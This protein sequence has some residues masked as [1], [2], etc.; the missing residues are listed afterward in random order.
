[1]AAIVARAMGHGN[2]RMAENLRHP[3]PRP[4]GN[5][6][7]A[8]SAGDAQGQ[9]RPDQQLHCRPSHLSPGPVLDPDVLYGSVD[10]Q[11]FAA[12]EPTI[13]ARYSRRYFGK[14]KGVVAYTLLANHVPL[15]TEL[16]GANE[17]ESHYVFDIWY[18]NTSA[19]VPTTITGDMHSVNKANFA[20]T[21]W[22][23][24]KFAPRFTSLQAQLQHLYCASDIAQ[25]EA[26]LLSPAG[27]IDRGLITPEKDNVDRIIAT[28][29]LKEM[30]QVRRSASCAP[31]PSKI[32]PERLSSNS[33]SWSAASTRSTTFGTRNCN[34]MSI[35]PRIVSKPIISCARPSHKSRQEA[36]DRH[37][38]T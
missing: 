10:G 29:G 1:M 7:A 18:H 14:G 15:E 8:Y 27:Q 5:R 20:V 9:L 36:A 6:P 23:G 19:I 34:A 28:L 25:Y 4:G 16:I 26:Y 32:R 22:F 37:H 2:S 12:A 35:A 3:L 11:K 21:H 33:I 38:R 24:A 30:S 17:H 31:C 13:K